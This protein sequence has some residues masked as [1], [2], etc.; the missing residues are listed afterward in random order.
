[1]SGDINTVVALSGTSLL[2]YTLLTVLL[3]AANN[4]DAK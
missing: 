3:P 1:M 4:F 2:E